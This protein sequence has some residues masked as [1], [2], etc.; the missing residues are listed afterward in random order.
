MYDNNSV[1]IEGIN[2]EGLCAMKGMISPEGRLKYA[3]D[4]AQKLWANVS[5]KSLSRADSVTLW[6]AAHQ[7]PPSVGFSRQEY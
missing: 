2:A 6:T 1:S 5:V 3:G 7:A 4:V